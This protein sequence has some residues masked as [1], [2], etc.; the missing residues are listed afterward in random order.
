[1]LWCKQN[2]LVLK[3]LITPRGNPSLIK[4]SFFYSFI[5][6]Q[7]TPVSAV[8]VSVD[9]FAL[10]T[11]WPWVVGVFQLPYFKEYLCYIICQNCIPF[12]GQWCSGLCAYTVYIQT[13]QYT[14]QTYNT[15]SIYFSMDEY[16]GHF[17]LLAIVLTV[18]IK[19]CKYVFP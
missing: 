16:L 18:A 15:S 1:M 12:Y 13:Y 2:Y 10:K 4:L 8:W 6:R 14:R 7:T 17:N 5:S 3:H 9:E 11:V 19:I